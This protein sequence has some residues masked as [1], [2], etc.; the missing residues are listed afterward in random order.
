M[1]NIDKLARKIKKETGFNITSHTLEFHGVC[2]ECLKNVKWTF[3]FYAFS[4]I[5]LSGD[6]YYD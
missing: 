4:D 2:P 1:G 5:I 3:F 6:L